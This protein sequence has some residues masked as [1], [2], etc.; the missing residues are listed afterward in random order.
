MPATPAWPPR[1]AP[2]LFVPGPL[3]EGGVVTLDGP[4]AHY[5]LR[6]MRVAEG[7]AVILC[8]DLTG[9][10]AGKV[11]QAG[12]RDLTLDLVERLRPREQ[13]PDLWL[14]AALL[15]KDRFD[16]VLEKATELGVRRIQPVLM[17]RCVADKLNLE[18]AR[19]VV[20][21]A[22]EQC[23]RTALPELAEPVKLDALLRD[24]PAERT[25]FFADEL[26]GGPAA[27]AFAAHL[28]PAALLVGPEGGFDDAEREAVRAAPQARPI[29]LGPRILRGETAAIAATAVWMGSIG[30]W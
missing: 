3:T 15:K 22:A 20:T 11:T 24:W 1:S 21:E 28:G 26:G 23:A 25:L 27:A 13:V 2:R 5:L 19:A 14:C 18:R 30:D 16:L 29:T 17:R 4:Q 8:D 9:E 10:W 6:V 7:D 12:K